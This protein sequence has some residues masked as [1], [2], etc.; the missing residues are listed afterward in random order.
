[1]DERDEQEYKVVGREKQGLSTLCKILE[2]IKIL[3]K[4]EKYIEQDQTF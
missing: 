4:K 1:M 3:F 2:K